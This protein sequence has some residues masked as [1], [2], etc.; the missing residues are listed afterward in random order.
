MVS[1]ID[2]MTE[3]VEIEQPKRQIVENKGIQLTAQE[4]DQLEEEIMKIIKDQIP[5]Y[6]QW[7]ALTERGEASKPCIKDTGNFEGDK[8]TIECPYCYTVAV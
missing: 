6:E 3:M 2:T 8:F 4:Q 1:T 7:P 5:M